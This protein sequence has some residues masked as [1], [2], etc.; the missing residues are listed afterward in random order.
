M[1][2]K[3][4]VSACVLSLSQL[5]FSHDMNKYDHEYKHC[6]HKAMKSIHLTQEQQTKMKAMKEQLHEKLKGREASMKE[7][8]SKIKVLIRSDKIDEHKLD[9]VVN[10]KK[11]LVGSMMK[12]NIMLRHDMYHLLDAKQKTEFVTKMDQC[13]EKAK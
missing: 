6:A 4:I 5:A 10:E 11:E 13:V 7:L 3:I 1:I 8:H 12:S 9:S 2:A